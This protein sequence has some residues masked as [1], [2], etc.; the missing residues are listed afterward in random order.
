M[1]NDDV[2]QTVLKVITQIC[3]TD[4]VL[5]EP[6]LDLF[7]AGI[8]DSMGFVE[9]LFA[10]EEELGLVVPPTDVDR[11]EVSSVNK[12]LEFVRERL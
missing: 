7:E 5:T 3:D 4:E 10:L 2:T 9:L 6:D 12:I 8:I 11:D 1:T